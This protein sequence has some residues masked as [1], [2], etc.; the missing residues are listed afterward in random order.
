MAHLKSILS[1]IC[2]IA[3]AIIIN[4]CGASSE[5][6]TTEDYEKGKVEAGWL[7]GMSPERMKK[8]YDGI[9]DSETKKKYANLYFKMLEAKNTSQQ[10]EVS[11]IGKVI[12][13][14]ETNYSVKI[15]VEGPIEKSWTFTGKGLLRDNLL[16]GEYLQYWE[17]NG[18][19]KY[20]M[21]DV[22]YYDERGKRKKTQEFDILKIE[23]T[24]SASFNGEP[25]NGVLNF[26]NR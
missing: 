9:T 16:P 26:H 20:K 10:T 19:K 14:N 3:F 6:N 21:K 17:R 2:I 1:V 5:V 12:I 18:S 7:T 24:T 22:Y 13:N 25:C 23:L 11:E 15:G 8:F 4:G